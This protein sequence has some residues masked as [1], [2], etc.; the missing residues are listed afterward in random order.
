MCFG[1]QGCIAAWLLPGTAPSPP[2]MDCLLEGVREGMSC[3]PWERIRF[4]TLIMIKRVPGE[5]SLT[6]LGDAASSPHWAPSIPAEIRVTALASKAFLDFTALQSKPILRYHFELQAS[7]STASTPNTTAWAQ[8][9]VRSCPWCLR[10]LCYDSS[11]HLLD[12]AASEC[13]TVP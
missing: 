12:G 1:V 2:L 8:A 10:P 4:A 3:R 6:R 7:S 11:S 13:C 9:H 5:I